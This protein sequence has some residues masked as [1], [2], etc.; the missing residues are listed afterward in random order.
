MYIYNVYIDM[1]VDLFWLSHRISLSPFPTLR[2]HSGTV[3]GPSIMFQAFP[4]HSIMLLPFQPIPFLA[5]STPSTFLSFTTISGITVS[6][7]YSPFLSVPRFC[8]YSSV[9]ICTPFL[10]TVLRPSVPHS[11]HT[12]FPTLQNTKTPRFPYEG[13]T[14]KLKP[15]WWVL[16]LS[17]SRAS[18]IFSYLVMTKRPGRA[19]GQEPAVKKPVSWEEWKL[20]PKRPS[21]AQWR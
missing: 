17:M 1:N 19:H 6:L 15:C 3:S 20:W 8:P 10:S 11:G 12:P 18:Q 2:H 21:L 13:A 4:A 9:S 16:E 14:H 7:R 5:P